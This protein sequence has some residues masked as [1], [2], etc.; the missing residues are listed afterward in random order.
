MSSIAH[1]ISI[2]QHGDEQTS[3]LS[4]LSAMTA[5]G[6]RHFVV[7]CSAQEALQTAQQ[8]RQLQTTAALSQGVNNSSSSS[9]SFLG[10]LFASKAG[11]AAGA[12]DAAGR[13]DGSPNTNTFADTAAMDLQNTVSRTLSSIGS[14]FSFGKQSASSSQTGAASAAAA[15]GGSIS[16]TAPAASASLVSSATASQL[17]T[18][19]FLLIQSVIGISDI[20]AALSRQ[21]GRE[22]AA[23]KLLQRLQQGGAMSGS[24][25]AGPVFRG[26]GLPILH[27]RGHSSAGAAARAGGG[28]AGGGSTTGSVDGDLRLHTETA[29]SL[30]SFSVGDSLEDREERE[31]Q[32]GR[33]RRGRADTGS[34]SHDSRSIE[35]GKDGA[36]VA[37]AA[38]VSAVEGAQSETGKVLSKG[39]SGCLLAPAL[40][41][42]RL[43]AFQTA[44][45]VSNKGTRKNSNDEER[46]KRKEL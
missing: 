43:L 29:S 27:A 45:E 32:G 16:A 9:G 31:G 41:I 6:F 28:A 42:K 3:Y 37:A 36:G 21:L 5:G 10:S 38:S 4:M 7:T 25:A 34:S 39:G 13:G 17:Q 24:T 15:G 12:A 40:A 33:E 22:K 1:P 11:G 14:F 8:V 23:R 19:P 2:L 44:I 35:G 20:M 46:M 18:E 30:D 26:S